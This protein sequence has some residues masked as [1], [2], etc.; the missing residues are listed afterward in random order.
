VKV[1]PRQEKLPDLNLLDIF[2]RNG[3]Q[4]GIVFQVKY[5]VYA[6]RQKRSRDQISISRNFD[7]L[8]NYTLAKEVSGQKYLP[9]LS[10]V[11]EYLPIYIIKLY[12]TWPL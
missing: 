11:C 10:R 12:E 1:N 7:I 9:I 4:H 3:V 5:L 2:I 8:C 6:V